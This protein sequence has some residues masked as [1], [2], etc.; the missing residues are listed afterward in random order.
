MKQDVL[1]SGLTVLRNAV[2]L[3]YPFVESLRSAQPLC[4]EFVVVV[5]ESD[6]E[7]LETVRALDLP[8]LRIVETEWSDKVRP[9]ECLLAQQT[10]I[11]L[12]LCRGTWCV[13]LQANEVLHEDS[14][15]PL[16][17]LMRE[18]AADERVEAMLVERLSFWA[19]YEH[20]LACYP[21][22]FKFTP[23]IVRPHIG[24]HSIR[25]AMSFAV[26]DDFS[27]RG[28]YPRSIDT[29]QYVYRYGHVRPLETLVQKY[30]DAV[31][32]RNQ[33][34]ARPDDD[35]FVTHHPRT[36]VRRFTGSHPEVMRDRVARFPAQ[37]DEESPS[38]RTRLTWKER[39]RAL[40]T[41]WYQRF[42]MPRWRNKRYKL[43]G[44]YARKDRIGDL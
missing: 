6:D 14:L 35:F 28:R 34:L 13:Y 26:F 5:G 41:R 1:V 30:R 2:A 12:H 40:E 22:R 3:D 9:S 31:H 24:T 27:T 4:D 25:D 32:M 29:G 7:T 8:N 42:G 33:D 16:L 18:H 39:R 20:V 11:G 36:F 44:S 19:D 17:A 10:N 38:C 23:R 15:P 37:Y 43:L 21:E